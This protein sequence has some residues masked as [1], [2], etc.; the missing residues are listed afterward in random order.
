[1]TDALIEEIY[2]IARE[3]FEGGQREFHVHAFPFRMTDENM[4]RHATIA[5]TASGRP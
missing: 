4:A 5:G 1:M 2:A 3:A